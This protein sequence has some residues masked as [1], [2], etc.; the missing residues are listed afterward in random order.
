M[1]Q[2]WRGTLKGFKDIFRY[3]NWIQLLIS[4]FFFRTRGFNIYYY[5]KLRIMVNNKAGDLAGLNECLLS[6]MYAQW[7][8]QMNLPTHPVVL[9]IGAHI[10]GFALLLKSCGFHPSK[11]V[12]VEMNP[13]TFKRLWFNMNEN[14]GSVAF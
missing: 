12:L 7:I 2:R 8:S 9:D 5:K 6:S 11:I 14:F 4:R 3:D 1:I 13:N 10:G